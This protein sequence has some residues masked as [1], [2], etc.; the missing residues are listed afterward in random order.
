MKYDHSNFNAQRAYASEINERIEKFL[1]MV[2]KLAWYYEGSCA[3]SLDVDDL[4]QAGMIALTECAQRHERPSE[5]GFAAYAKMRVRGAM[6]DLLRS[7]SHHVRGAAALRRK[8]EST[9]DEL[10]RNL[11][12]D[13][14]AEEIAHAMGI[15]VEEYHKARSQ[16]ATR[17]V[18]LGDCYSDTNPAFVSEEPDAEAQLLEAADK[19]ALTQAIAN[20]PERLRL[21]IQLHFLEE[22]NLTEIAA[23]L[24]VS[25]PRVHQLKANALEKLRIG[26]VA[27]ESA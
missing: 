11:G 27:A 26:L 7:Q 17:L 25:V 14:S 16:V 21:V 24:E 13:P 3:A 5:D 15:S 23:I 10:R 2:R 9:A 18:D 19:V 12:R 20:L 22:L 6:I 8:M 4:L 1:P